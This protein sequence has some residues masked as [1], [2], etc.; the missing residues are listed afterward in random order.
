ML[1]SFLEERR[2]GLER[3]LRMMSHHRLLANDEMFK[4][5]LTDTSP[6]HQG[7][8]QESF[9]KH[10]DEFAQVSA[11]FK[12]SHYEIEQ[13]V[14]Q[15]ELMRIILNHVVKLKR[16]MEQQSKREIN[17]SKDFMEMSQVLSS[18]MRDTDD[19]SFKDFTDNFQEISKESEKISLNQQRAVFERLTMLIEILTGH[20]DMCE[21]VEKSITIDHQA[22]SKTLNINT[23]KIRSVIRRSSV[24]DIKAMNEKQQNELHTLHKRNAFNINCVINET[25]FAQ[26]YL[27]L[28]PS[29]LLQFANEES[30]GFKNISEIFSKIIQVEIDKLS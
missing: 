19:E 4:I 29:I 30:K 3:W 16:L 21:R 9:F 12:Q 17:Q 20:S 28:L 6:D 5:F 18:I 26:K 10:P 25:K 11:D 2:C 22:L 13:L 24:D 14:T 1:D 27:K 15:R 23:Q 7:L 8:L